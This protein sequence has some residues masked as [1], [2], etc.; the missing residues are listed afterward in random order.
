VAAPGASDILLDLTAGLATGDDLR[1]VLDRFLQPIVQ[2]AGAQ[3]GAVRLVH[4]NEARMHLIGEI[5]LP[6]AVRDAEQS[7]E[8]DCGVCG[9]ARAG[10]ELAWSGES[11]PCARRNDARLL[12]GGIS[13]VLAVP[14]SH[15]GRVLG[16][17]N[18]FF[19]GGHEPPT[20]V[21][22]LLRA[23]GDLLGLALDNARLEREHLRAAVAGE[24][25]AIAADVHD[26]IGQ[27]LAYV[28][29]RL[30]LLHDAIDEGDRGA[31]E[32]YFKD[33][34]EAVGE[35]HASLRAVLTQMRAPRDPQGLAH[36]L[37]ASAAAFRARGTTM[38]EFVDELRG[39]QLEPD[40]EEQV[41]HIVQE[42]L[43]NITRHA[44]ARHAW[45]HVAGECGVLRVLVQD[46]GGGL[47]SSVSGEG[48]HYGLAI[49]RE[50]ARRLGGTLEV[51]LR[52]GGGTRVCLQVP[53]APHGTPAA[54]EGTV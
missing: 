41:F 18:L 20:G 47:P 50:R 10:D 52:A 26:S 30:P 43:A 19:G 5:G 15:R 29:M 1:E 16:V 9:A 45:L 32:R 2:V 17:L 53:C 51:G 23:I 6:A 4:S 35:A 12:A 13:R 54:A 44:A 46:D 7:V 11:T 40:Q 48:A 34:R 21:P 42:A 27:S 33:V 24:R 3:A 39:M 37:A 25:Q 49:M 31:A 38:L 28:K 8:H 22:A 14:L 36:A